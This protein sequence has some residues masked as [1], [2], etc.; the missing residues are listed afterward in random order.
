MALCSSE[1]VILRTYDLGNADKIVVA[2]TRGYGKVRGVAQGARRL[3]SPFAGRLERFN[4]VEIGYFEKEGQELVKIDRVELLRAFASSLKEYRSFLQLSLMAELLFETTPDHEPNDPL[5]RLVVLVL[6]EMQDPARS[7][8]AQLYFQVW[9]LKLS[10]LFPATK[11]C[12]NCGFS[13]LSA[14]QVFYLPDL[15][16]FFC[17]SCRGTHGQPIFA[18]SFWL[19]DQIVTKKLRMIVGDSTGETQCF[20]LQRIM[21]KMLRQSFEREFE[22]LKL[23]RE[24][25]RPN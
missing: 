19:L 23:L 10:G 25:F 6:E 8:L 3:K 20:E 12:A 24:G 1:A 16:G 22:S 7:D 21:D 17:P 13:L 4:W 2:L 14:S 5:F 9:Y 11:A 15:Q 18:G